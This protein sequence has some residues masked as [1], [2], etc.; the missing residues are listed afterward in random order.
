MTT[1]ASALPYGVGRIG[2]GAVALSVLLL[3]VAAVGVI[4][5]VHQFRQGLIVTGLRDW[6]TRGGAPWGVYIAFDVYF[7]GVSFAGIT[8]AALIRLLNL[9]HLRPISRMAELLTIVSL[10]LAGV[11]ILADLGQPLR[12]I[13]NLFR[14]ARPQSPFFGTFSLVISGYLFAS[15]V[16]FYLAG[17]RDA[18]LMAQ[19]PSPLRG[20]YRLWAAGYRDTPAQRRRHERVSFWLALGIIPLLITAHS[21]LGLVFGLMSG[22]PGWFSALQAPGFVVMAG[23]SGIGHIAV[24]AAIYRRFLPG[25]ERIDRSVFRWLGMFLLILGLTY[26]YFTL[27]ELL[28]TGYAGTHKEQELAR[29]LLLGRYAPYFWVAMGALALAIALNA[30][31]AF[32]GRW[33]I[34]LVVASGVL[35]NITAIGKRLLIVTPSLTHGALLPYEPGTYV[36]TWVEVAIILGLMALGAL[37]ILLFGKVFPI[38]ELAPETERE[39]KEV[40]A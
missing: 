24:L 39:R 37:A 14:Y 33:S 30:W 9:Q 25:G 4:A 35:V 38:I 32:T 28:T 21:T 27:I 7:V 17:R 22:R 12:G 15:L 16:Y 5:Y 18:Y 23:L 36:P 11:T 2:R 10:M 20:F 1:R 31:Q 26:V 8:V 19:Q 40:L 3:L 6:G 29:L 13:V 34:A